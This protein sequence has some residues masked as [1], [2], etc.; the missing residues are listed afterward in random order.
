LSW[1]QHVCWAETSVCVAVRTVLIEPLLN[2]WLFQLVV[3]DACI[4]LCNWFTCHNIL[5]FLSKCWCNHIK[6]GGV[7]SMYCWLGMHA[8]YCS[9][10]LEGKKMSG[11]PRQ[12]WGYKI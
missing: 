8:W 11:R 6:E 7:G 4:N 10:N 5:Y 12:R 2:N 9:G 3:P 1:K